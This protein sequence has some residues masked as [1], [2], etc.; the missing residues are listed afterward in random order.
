MSRPNVT[1]AAVNG[2]LFARACV[3]DQRA[4]SHAREE[5]NWDDLYRAALE[6]I[7]AV[8]GGHKRAVKKAARR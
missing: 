3:L 6:A 7:D 2:L 4:L 1:D 8:V 5:H